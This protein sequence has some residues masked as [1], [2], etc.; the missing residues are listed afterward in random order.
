MNRLLRIWGVIAVG[1]VA[2][3]HVGSPNVFFEGMAGPYSVRVT[4]RPPIVIPGIAD[5]TIRLI[6]DDEV[7]RVTVQP[8]RWDAGEAGAP[9]PD[10]A[11]PV[12]GTRGL[13]AA[14]LWFMTAG[15]HSIH[16]TVVGERGTGTAV[17][18]VTPVRITT[19]QME[20][21]Y[22]AMLLAL[23]AF[24][25]IGAI[26]IMGAAV[27]ESVLPPGNHPN[28]RRR[29]R[30]GITMAASGLVFAGLVF[31]GKTWWDSVEAS[32]RRGIF[33][34]LAITT[35]VDT[36]GSERILTLTIDDE[37]WLDRQWTPLVP[38]HGKLMHMFMVRAPDLDAFAHVH[39]VPLDSNTFA[40]ALPPLPGGSYRIYADVLHESGFTQTLVDTT[41]IPGATAPPR[42][43]PTGVRR[44]PDDSWLVT[45]AAME[46]AGE[47]SQA[48]NTVDTLA[49]GST[50]T[51]VRD[52]ASIAARQEV[53]LRFRVHA[54]DGRPAGLEPY[55]GMTSHAA[56]LR[57][58]GAVFVHLHPIGSISVGSQQTFLL[59]V[60]GDSV[61]G[62][63][64]RRITES[65]AP[66]MPTMGTGSEPGV[67]TL[68]YE[69]PEP[70]AYRIWV[71]VKRAGTVLTGVF[72][73]SVK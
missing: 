14:A 9:P 65:P 50:M 31:L 17:V 13:Y 11:Q 68:P 62:T 53:E 51:W 43:R 59:R 60:P 49:D 21:A 28:K 71:Q 6:G 66:M 16:V 67:I 47:R 40:V 54:S 72:D 39:P 10:L 57:D 18:P 70:G 12:P 58:D 73:A 3:A 22:G 36:A 20:R 45:T 52:T 1:L 25:F 5:I 61:I 29:V 2:S 19:L 32:Y 24:L 46:G 8:F 69:F 27:R 37:R 15:S 33:R 56:I 7:H 48:M 23:G 41:D 42:D 64:G 35:S 55:M 44:D 4:I 38:D 30:A 26:T 34:P 63:L